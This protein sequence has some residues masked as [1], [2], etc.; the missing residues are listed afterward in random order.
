M[1]TAM[2]N[3]YWL[4]GMQK[5]EVIV[6]WCASEP[7]CQK[8]KNG[9]AFRLIELNIEKMEEEIENLNSTVEEHDGI[10]GNC[11]FF[12]ED[13]MILSNSQI[14]SFL[15]TFLGNGIVSSLNETANDNN[16]DLAI[17]K[18]AIG[19]TILDVESLDEEM[20]K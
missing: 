14:R 13:F 6:I 11:Y 17:L 3:C 8:E 10:L 4:K 2:L 20:G 18:N 15:I 1:L 7:K 19:H 16:L 5:D 9:L 12:L